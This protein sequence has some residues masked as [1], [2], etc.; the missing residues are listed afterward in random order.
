M[1]L[2][3]SHS[4][5]ASLILAFAGGDGSFL[6]L[7]PPLSCALP[8][9]TFVCLADWRLFALGLLLTMPSPHISPYLPI[10]PHISPYLR[11]APHLARLLRFRVAQLRSSRDAAEMQPRSVRDLAQGHR[12]QRCEQRLSKQRLSHT[13][14]PCVSSLCLCTL[15]YPSSVT[16]SPPRLHPPVP[17]PSAQWLVRLPSHL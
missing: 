13:D 9:L 16:V 14:E 4:R 15:R 1:R 5:Q 3:S 6:P 8:R 12:S 11:L 10:S 17:P 2:S 7:A